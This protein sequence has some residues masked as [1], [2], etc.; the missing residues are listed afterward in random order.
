MP[1]G[2]A[3]PLRRTKDGKLVSRRS[4]TGNPACSAA[5]ALLAQGKHTADS[6]KVL[7]RCRAQARNLRD[8]EIRRGAGDEAG[9]ARAERRAARGQTEAERQSRQRQADTIRAGRATRPARTVARPAA[10]QRSQEEVVR[11][12]AKAARL[13]ELR[14][15]SQAGRDPA[16]HTDH[17]PGH[18]GE[19]KTDLIRFDPNRF[20]YKLDQTNSSTGSVGSLA[21]VKRWDPELAGVVQVWK[22]PKNGQVFVINGHNRLEL[23]NKLGVD[24]VAV[25][26]ISAGNAAEARA[27]GAL[28]NIAEGRGTDIDAAKFFRD[29]GIT[30]ADL[31]SRGIPMTEAKAER[32]LALSGL[33]NPLFRKVVYKEMPVER[34]AIIGGS[35]LSH[36]QQMKVAALVDRRRGEVTNGTLREIVDEVKIAPTRQSGGGGLFGDDPEVE[37]LAIFRASLT[38]RVKERL[39]REK[40][41]FGTV[42]RER[43]ARELSRAGN[44]IDPRASGEISRQAS[45]ALT[46]F[47]RLKRTSVFSSPLNDASERLASAR[48]PAERKRI[49]DDLYREILERVRDAYRFSPAA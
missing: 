1:R 3:T 25:R 11:R 4:K 9:A 13:R 5:A 47:D 31:E 27:K 33:A 8:A 18:I 38:A 17:P 40:K 29:S 46:T 36:D 6:Q 48:T 41:L 22:D 16:T 39:G 30:R 44:V 37:S 43:S 34:G 28:T 21:G 23:A 35:G 2:R 45:E 14:A 24:R 42:A 49:E 19:L 7:G 12:R 26:F 15:K 10:V 32:G 20:Q